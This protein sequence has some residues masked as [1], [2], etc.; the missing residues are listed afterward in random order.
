M[1]HTKEISLIQK[2]LKINFPTYRLKHNMRFKRII[3]IDGT[4]YLLSDEASRNA[5]YSR[6]L[7]SMLYL[8]SFEKEPTEIAVKSFLN[9]K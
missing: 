8:F 3:I 5:L 6:L 2:F 9:M 1:L 7:N 4:K